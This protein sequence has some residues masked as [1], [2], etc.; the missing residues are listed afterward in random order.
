MAAPERGTAARA[1]DQRGLLCAA[2]KEPA[3]YLF[4]GAHGAALGL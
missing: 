2:R 4:S 1:G 3:L